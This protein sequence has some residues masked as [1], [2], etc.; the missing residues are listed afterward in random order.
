[1]GDQSVLVRVFTHP[2]CSGC[3]TAVEWAWRLKKGNPDGIELRTV[4]LEDKEGLDEAHTENVKT[5]PTIIISRNGQELERIIGA[6]KP[7]QLDRWL[8]LDSEWKVLETDTSMSQ[9]V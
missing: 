7:E 5:I 1:M 8:S 4:S 9:E 2:A 6:P 3:L